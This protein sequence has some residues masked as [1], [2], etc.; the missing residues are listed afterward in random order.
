MPFKSSPFKTAPMDF[1][2]CVR[3]SHLLDCMDCAI[4]A[5]KASPTFANTWACGKSMRKPSSSGH[6]TFSMAAGGGAKALGLD[7]SA[8][9]VASGDFL[10]GDAGDASMASIRGRG[11]DAAASKAAGCSAATGL[12][13]SAPGWLAREGDLGSGCT[14]ASSSCCKEPQAVSSG[15]V[16]SACFSTNGL[17]GVE[18][19]FFQKANF[20]STPI[21]SKLLWHQ[22]GAQGETPGAHSLSLSLLAF[23]QRLGQTA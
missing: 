18:S 7:E 9:S 21:C 23:L 5:P 12:L 1:R 22:T 2:A 3:W 15:V 10:T 8:R 14:T 17:T 13:I 6:S 4:M 16:S 20:L 19:F 11:G